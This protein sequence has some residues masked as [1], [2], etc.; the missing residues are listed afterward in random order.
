MSM[1][2]H[3][4]GLE[5]MASHLAQALKGN[6]VNKSSANSSGEIKKHAIHTTHK[7]KEAKRNSTANTKPI[8]RTMSKYQAMRMDKWRSILL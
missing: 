2:P 8:E 6:A 4:A 7:E 5:P 3:T 1:T